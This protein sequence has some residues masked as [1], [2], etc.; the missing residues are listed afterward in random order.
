MTTGMVNTGRGAPR[1]APPV[2]P[3]RNASAA[4]MAALRAETPGATVAAGVAAD[5]VAATTGGQRA[6]PPHL[7]VRPAQNRSGQNQVQSNQSNTSG[8]PTDA[9]RGKWGDD[10]YDAYG[11]GQHRGSSSMGGGRGFAWQSDGSAERPFLGPAGGFVEGASG[12]D[13]RQRGGFRGYRGRGGGRGRF[14]RPPPPRVA[15][16]AD[17]VMDTDHVAQEL[18]SQAMEVVNALAVVDVPGTAKDTEAADRAEVE[19]ASKYAR[20]KE[21]MLCYRCGE[22]GHFIAECV[23]QLC[24]SCGK[25]A[26]ASGECPFLREQ[27]P[28]LT[29]YGVYCAELMFFESTAAREI[30]VDALLPVR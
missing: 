24:D 7:A 25:P 15:D 2:V 1:P 11:V 14:R 27:T 30:P 20:K 17:A 23:A 22:K 28:A 13:H 12:P 5:P 29:V 4:G 9:P 6:P 10:G 19:R 8:R 3:A 18:P 21:R 26:H 16:T